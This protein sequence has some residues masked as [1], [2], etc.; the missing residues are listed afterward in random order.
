MNEKAPNIN[1]A[2]GEKN[3]NRMKAN[4]NHRHHEKRIQAVNLGGFF[5][6]WDYLFKTIEIN[7]LNELKYGVEGYVPTL[8][9]FKNQFLEIYKF[10]RSKFLRTNGVQID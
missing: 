2:H 9:P 6:I 10:I 3:Q 4:Q 5:T 7:S 8:N 1:K